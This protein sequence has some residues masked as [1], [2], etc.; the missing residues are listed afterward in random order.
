MV[1]RGCTRRE[2]HDLFRMAQDIEFKSTPERSAVASPS[3]ARPA[4]AFGKVSC[5]VLTMVSPHLASSSAWNWRDDLML[6]VYIGDV[7]FGG[8]LQ[9]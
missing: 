6:S 1:G 5:F 8:N 7:T 3:L 2:G 9:T 4:C